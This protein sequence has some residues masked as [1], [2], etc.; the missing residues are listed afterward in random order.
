MVGNYT[1]EDVSGFLRSFTNVQ[2]KEWPK[3]WT[4]KQGDQ[5]IRKLNV[6]ES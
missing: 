6:D 5:Y 3:L 1:K 2:V 4:E